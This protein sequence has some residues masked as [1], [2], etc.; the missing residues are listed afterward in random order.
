ML[1]ALPVSFGASAKAQFWDRTPSPAHG[2]FWSG[3]HG[4]ASFGL[5]N[6]RGEGSRTE[7]IFASICGLPVLVRSSG[8]TFSAGDLIFLSTSCSACAPRLAEIS[9]CT[10]FGVHVTTPSALRLRTDSRRAIT[11]KMWSN[12]FDFYFIVYHFVHKRSIFVMDS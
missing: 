2:G 5:A 3:A 7:L 11:K 6:S 8:F 9:T 4:H 1:A 12:S 10:P